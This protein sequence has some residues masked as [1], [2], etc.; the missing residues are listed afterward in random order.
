M[1]QDPSVELELHKTIKDYSNNLDQL[2]KSNSNT[3]AIQERLTNIIKNW[4]LIS[5][6]CTES[7]KNNR[8]QLID[9]SNQLLYDMNDVT[10]MYEQLINR[11]LDTEAINKAGRQ[12]MLS[13]R[14]ALDVLA[15]HMNLDVQMHQQQLQK[16]IALFDRQLDELNIYTVNNASNEAVNTLAKHWK[17]YK[18]YTTGSLSATE[19]TAL[20]NDNSSFLDACENLVQKILIESA[21]QSKVAALI[22]VAGKQRM[23]CQRI[24]FY[25]LAYRNEIDKKQCQTILNSAIQALKTAIHQLQRASLNTPTTYA[26]VDKQEKLIRRLESYVTNIDEVD[27][28]Q[29]L[30][31]SNIL[32]SEAEALVQAYEKL[33]QP[34]P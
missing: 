27:L 19:L 3:K 9:L 28:F 23:L 29:I 24:T 13:Q 12:R 8:I 10:N 20:V 18:K 22:Q 31:T 34:T 21:T 17:Q 4:E 2:V 33:G 16:S 14:I 32:L 25:A 15:I 1:P 5:S 30:M 7:S 11:L 6:I 26:L